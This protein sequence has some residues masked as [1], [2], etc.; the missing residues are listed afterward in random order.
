VARRV[1]NFGGQWH[2]TCDRDN[3]ACV[4]CKAQ[5]A[6][7]NVSLGGRINMVPNLRGVQEWQRGGNSPYG[8]RKRFPRH[9]NVPLGPR[10]VLRWTECSVW[11]S[12]RAGAGPVPKFGGPGGVPLGIQSAMLAGKGHSKVAPKGTLLQRSAGS[13]RLKKGSDPKGSEP[14]ERKR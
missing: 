12:Q 5:C 13:L 11:Q 6:T 2:T 4:L 8:I 10:T 7:C 9:H 3:V 14:Q 1:P